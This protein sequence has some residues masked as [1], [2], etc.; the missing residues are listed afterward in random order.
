MSKDFKS[1]GRHAFARRRSAD[2]AKA[3]APGGHHP[4]DVY[5]LQS[6]MSATARWHSAVAAAGAYRAYIEGKP[7]HRFTGSVHGFP[8]WVPFEVLDIAGIASLETA[9]TS[10]LRLRESCHRLGVDD[11][12]LED[13]SRQR[14]KLRRLTC[15]CL[16]LALPLGVIQAGGHP[17][18]A[19]VERGSSSPTQSTRSRRQSPPDGYRPPSR[20]SVDSSK[21]LSQPGYQS[22]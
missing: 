13:T 12:P 5:G 1:A 19:V 3:A 16:R 2:M 21:A 7:L 22:Q 11:D 8:D 15:R 20:R 10:R 14:G 4:S 6:S 9:F 18:D 17:V